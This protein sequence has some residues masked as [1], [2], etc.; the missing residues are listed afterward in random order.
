M[1]ESASIRI[2]LVFI[3]DIVYT[4]LNAFRGKFVLLRVNKLVES[5]VSNTR[6]CHIKPK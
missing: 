3:G 2:R 4:A 5:L 1:Y 6:T